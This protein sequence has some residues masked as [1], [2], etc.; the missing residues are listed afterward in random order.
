MYASNETKKGNKAFS[1][2][3]CT[4][5][6]ITVST[7]VSGRLG[8][9]SRMEVIL[10]SMNWTALGLPRQSLTTR[11]NVRLGH[12][13][14]GPNCPAEDPEGTA[15]GARVGVGRG[16]EAPRQTGL[17]LECSGRW[18]NGRAGVW[19]TEVHQRRPGAEPRWGSGGEAP[20]SYRYN[21]ILC[22]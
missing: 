13:P 21:V 20:W 10:S 14:P 7:M 2:L 6:T 9:M 18:C 11:P 4:H 16:F 5:L 22:L 3:F 19:G 12:R 17:Y 8:A 1:Y 15:G